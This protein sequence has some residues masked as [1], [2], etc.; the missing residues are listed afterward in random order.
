[1]QLLRKCAYSNFSDERRFS[2]VPLAFHVP[3]SSSMSSI[4]IKGGIGNIPF[5]QLFL[6]FNKKV[7]R[8]E[9]FRL[10]SKAMD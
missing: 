2:I 5:M 7:E 10:V 6:F 9:A 8:K 4:N 1:M 3:Q